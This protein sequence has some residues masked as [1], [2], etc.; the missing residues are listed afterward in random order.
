MEIGSGGPRQTPE[1]RYHLLRK[2]QEQQQEQTHDSSPTAEPS[3]FFASIASYLRE[4]FKKVASGEEKHLV[5]T[6]KEGIKQHLTAMRKMFVMLAEVDHSYNPEF[7]V[8]MSVVWNKIIDDFSFL[9]AV[10]ISR[11]VD[12]QKLQ[13]FLDSINNYPPNE[14]FTMGG[15]LTRYAGKEWHP[16]PLMNILYGLHQNYQENQ[17]TSSLIQWIGLLNEVIGSF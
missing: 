10:D 15:Y 3:A 7:I 1:E 11:T 14:D 13:E 5:V 9:K 12:T 4:T 6:Q 17:E 2:Q 8:Q 16:F